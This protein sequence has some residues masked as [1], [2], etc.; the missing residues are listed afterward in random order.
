MNKL[1]NG[2]KVRLVDD[3]ERSGVLVLLGELNGRLTAGVLFNG[4]GSPVV[5]PAEYIERIS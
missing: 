2:D 4:E 3:H 5:L 1:R